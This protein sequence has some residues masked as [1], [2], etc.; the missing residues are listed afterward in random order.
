[1]HLQKC[2]SD[3]MSAGNQRHGVGGLGGVPP[4]LPLTSL[5]FASTYKS[6]IMPIM[7][8]YARTRATRACGGQT[9][10]SAWRGASLIWR[11]FAEI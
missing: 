2:I 11:S 4:R 9:G 5:P 7:L 10:P 3:D 6:R 8:M 1:M